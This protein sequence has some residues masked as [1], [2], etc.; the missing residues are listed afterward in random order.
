M[1]KV[2][3]AHYLQVRD[4]DFDDFDRA[5]ACA[6]K[7]GAP[8]AKNAAQRTDAGNGDDSHDVQETLENTRPEC[9]FVGNA[10]DSEYPRQESN[11]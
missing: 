7:S 5:L 2:A 6:A 4:S 11:L 9:V 3:A 8:E 10:A 1:P